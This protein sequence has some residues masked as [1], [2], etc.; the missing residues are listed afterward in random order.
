MKKILL[1]SVLI[2][3]LFLN[4]LGQIEKPISKG[5]L[6]VGGALDFSTDKSNHVTSDGQITVKR[7]TTIFEGT[8]DFGYFMFNKFSTGIEI[9]Y[10]IK[11]IDYGQSI[12]TSDELIIG[13][14]FRYYTKIGVFAKGA[15]GLG[16]YYT[17]AKV[18][19]VKF[20]DFLWD[21]GFGYS[22]FLN[23]NIALETFVSYYELRQTAIKIAESDN[24]HRGLNITLGF[25]FYFSPE[26]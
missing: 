25:K 7:E 22:L 3:I 11:R 9:K 21:I 24:E 23:K 2:T 18:D 1:L 13:P 19:P 4:A 26:Q 20:R 8:I 16:Y 6:W 5:S 15:L 10:F 14:A 17:G 12:T